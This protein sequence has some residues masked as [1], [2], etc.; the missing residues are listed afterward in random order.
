[1]ER[2]DFSAV[3]RV[4]PSHHRQMQPTAR[5]A[6][7]TV[8]SASLEIHPNAGSLEVDLGG[9]EVEELDL[10]MNAGSLSLQTDAGTQLAGSIGV[11]AGSVDL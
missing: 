8:S 10:Q 9:S 4:H 2:D 6:S 5:W 7:S 1:M 11:N 3:T